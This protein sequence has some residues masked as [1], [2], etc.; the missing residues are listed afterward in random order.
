LRIVR[1]IAVVDTTL[2]T[3]CESCKKLCPT[4]AVTMTG[5]KRKP[6]ASIDEHAC[7][8]C[9]I[10]GA[11]CPAEA[12]TMAP[13]SVPLTIGVKVAD[14]PAEKIA[15]ICHAAHLFPDQIVCGCT[16]VQAKE[17][18]AAI[19][20]GASTPEEVARKTGARTGC[21]VLCISAVIRLLRGAGIELDKAPGYQWYGSSVSIWNVPPEVMRKYPEYYLAQDREILDKVFPGGGK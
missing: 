11:R 4:L 9:S 13:R 8:A 19:L 12:I 10:C 14:V 7:V 6:K 17:I 16:R 20:L 21:G 5:P 1:Q 18:A 3:G 15:A 2:C